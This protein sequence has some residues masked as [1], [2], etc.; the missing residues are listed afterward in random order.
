MALK[1]S[2]CMVIVRL[3]I[4]CCIVLSLK[5]VIGTCKSDAGGGGVVSRLSNKHFK[6][7]ILEVNYIILSKVSD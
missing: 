1:I 6:P 3:Y 5:F 4:I 7:Y 2:I